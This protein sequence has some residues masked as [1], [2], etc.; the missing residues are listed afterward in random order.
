MFISL[1]LAGAQMKKVL[2]SIGSIFSIYAFVLVG[3]CVCVFFFKYKT[4]EDEGEGLLL[5]HSTIFIVY[6]LGQVLQF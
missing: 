4:Y 6:G 5:S 1:D 3:V 2:H